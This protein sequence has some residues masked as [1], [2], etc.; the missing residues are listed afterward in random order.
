MHGL[1]GGVIGSNSH[2]ST[3]LLRPVLKTSGAYCEDLFRW[4]IVV[5]EPFPLTSITEI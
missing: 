5:P 3:T 4:R 1:F 2:P